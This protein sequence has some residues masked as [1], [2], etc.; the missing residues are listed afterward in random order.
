MSDN[1]L[2][3]LDDE[4]VEGVSGGYL[5]NAE[6]YVTGWGRLDKPYEVID[7][8]GEVVARF[9]SVNAAIAFAEENGYSTT[10]IDLEEVEKI[11]AKA[12]EIGSC[13]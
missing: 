9:K 6:H 4:Q 1:P 7:D 10:W 2:K 3:P 11:R 13:K 5:L 12:R 8:Y